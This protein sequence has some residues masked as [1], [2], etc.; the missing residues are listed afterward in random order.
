VSTTIAD[1]DRARGWSLEGKS[2]VVSGA[3]SGLGRESARLLAQR[4]AK[5][6]LVDINNGALEA[7]TQT[8]RDESLDV[9][10]FVA[11]FSD[12]AQI[13]AA[14]DESV[15]RFGALDFVHNNAGALVT[16]PLL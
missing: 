2:G 16:R 10:S 3:A 12:S 6:L 8:L 9:T 11:D 1:T 15:T 14:L 5:V 7:A 4:G 13:K